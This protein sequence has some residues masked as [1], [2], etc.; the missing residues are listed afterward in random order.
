MDSFQFN[1]KTNC[2]NSHNALHWLSGPQSTC[3]GWNQVDVKPRWSRP[4]A[5]PP[6]CYSLA[7]LQLHCRLAQL[8]ALIT[9]AIPLCSAVTGNWGTWVCPYR[10]SRAARQEASRDHFYCWM[11]KA[12]STLILSNQGTGCGGGSLQCSLMQFP[13]S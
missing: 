13:L 9:A 7:A 11:V 2:R 1:R 8:L 6:S 12:S 3:L 4:P 10:Q 5:S